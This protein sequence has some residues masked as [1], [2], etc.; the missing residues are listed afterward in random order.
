M[1]AVINAAFLLRKNVK[2]K[3]G[4]LRSYFWSFA[5]QNSQGQTAPA[6]RPAGTNSDVFAKQKR[7]AQK[8]HGCHFWAAQGIEAEFLRSKNWSG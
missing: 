8:W 2:P 7:K 4:I 5:K 6:R 3:N 1:P